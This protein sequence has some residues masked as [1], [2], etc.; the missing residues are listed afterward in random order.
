[1]RPAVR[2]H[3][4]DKP[5]KI[6][7]QRA[8]FDRTPHIVGASRILCH[9]CLYNLLA[10]AYQRATIASATASVGCG[11]DPMGLMH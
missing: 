9:R 1:M 5:N 11:D 2:Q 10:Y 7:E 8:A 3:W 6:A 4:L